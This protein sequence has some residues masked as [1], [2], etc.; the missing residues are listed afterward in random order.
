MWAMEWL[1]AAFSMNRLVRDERRAKPQ[2]ALAAIAVIIMLA[3]V[4]IGVYTWQSLGN[5]PMD[6][7]GYLALVLGVIGTVA[8]GGGLM[9]LVFFSHRYG[10]DEKVGG[11]AKSRDEP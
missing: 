7:N 2:R 5:V 8:L 1:R 11:G 6:A 9:A 10:Y 3:L 4:G